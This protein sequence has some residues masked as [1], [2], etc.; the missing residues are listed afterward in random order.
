MIADEFDDRRHKPKDG[1]QNLMSD[2]HRDDFEIEY[3]KSLASLIH[4]CILR[5]DQLRGYSVEDF[6]N[7]LNV[8]SVGMNYRQVHELTAIVYAVVQ[9]QAGQKPCAAQK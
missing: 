5:R 3:R 9:F 4:Q 7:M 6:H 2:V 1:Y 8:E